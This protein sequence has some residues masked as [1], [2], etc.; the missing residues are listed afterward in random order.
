MSQRRA[1]T[2]RQTPFSWFAWAG[3][4]LEVPAHWRPIKIRDEARQG[5]FVFGD[6][7]QAIG[8]VRWAKVSATDFNAGKWIRKRLGKRAVLERTAPAASR[9]D[10]TLW[11]PEAQARKGPPCSIWRGYSA[12]GNLALEIVINGEVDAPTRK[13]VRRK[14]LPSIDASAENA[15]TRWA[16]LDTS[17]ES[18]P[19]YRLGSKR[20]HLGDIMLSLAHGRRRLV[21]RQVY[22]AGVALQRQPLEQWMDDGCAVERRRYSRTQEDE[23]WCVDS[24]GRRLEGLMRTGSKRLPF[25]LGRVAPRSSVV[26]A[27]VDEA[28]DR[29]L[30]AMYDAGR[31]NNGSEAL[32]ESVGMMNWARLEKVGI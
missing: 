23:T 28:L 2:R 5:V 17:F 32:A 21:L 8:V 1:A 15:P 6:G 26:V 12:P 29:V 11:A 24:F 10:A 19:G 13:I 20:I 31:G 4:K 22:P 9:F 3:W 27:A 30:V 14:V 16:V 7:R 25:P 18:P